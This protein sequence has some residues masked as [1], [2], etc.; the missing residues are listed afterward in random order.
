MVGTAGTMLSRD[1]ACVSDVREGELVPMDLYLMVDKTGSMLCPTGPDGVGCPPQYG[2]SGPTRWDSVSAAI[3]SFVAS[4]GTNGISVGIGFF[5]STGAGTYSCLASDYIAPAVEIAPLPPAAPAIARAIDQQTVAGITPTT[6][7]L[8]G[9]LTHAKGWASSHAG[10]RVAVVYATDGEPG[11]CGLDNNV[12]RAAQIAKAGL[13]AAPS[14][15]TYVLGVG[16]SLDSLN[17]IAVAGGTGKAYFVD[18]GQ[19]V[20]Q[21]FVDALNG[22]RNRSITCDYAIPTSTRGPLDYSL[23][24]VEAQLGTRGPATLVTHVEGASGCDAMT[25][26]WYYDQPSSP[27][28]I[29]LC[30]ATCQPLSSTQGS[31]LEVIIGCRTV[32]APVK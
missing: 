5:P 21:Q 15:V 26:G 16:P 9:A 32:A 22:I 1:A 25:G 18:T 2:G 6:A 17:Q 27:S 8:E 14:V 24:N 7:S 28:V 20:T 19:N 12:G 11:G 29:S 30:P 13:D 31:R 23:V 4:S 10:R 3:K